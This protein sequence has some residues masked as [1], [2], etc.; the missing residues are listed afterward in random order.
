MYP[1]KSLTSQKK[2]LLILA[3]HHNNYHSIHSLSFST[4]S[5]SFSKNHCEISLIFNFS[6]TSLLK[7]LQFKFR[8][9]FIFFLL[10]SPLLI[11]LCIKIIMALSTTKGT[12]S[13]SFTQQCKYD[14]FLS[15]KGEDTCNGFTSH[16][17]G[18][19]RHNGINT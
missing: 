17:N 11:H 7:L 8:H 2:I 10:S 1:K 6:F 15:F 9:I 16:L 12:S 14:V 5:H 13:S 3:W 19:L 18:I 4:N